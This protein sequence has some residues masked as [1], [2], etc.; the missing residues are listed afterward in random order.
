MVESS[1]ASTLFQRVLM[2]AAILAASLPAAEICNLTFTGCPQTFNGD[3]IMVP[4][5]VVK[6]SS[7]VH[8]CNASQT[9]TVGGGG[10]TCS[11]VF[12]IDNT[13]SM[14]GANGND[15]TGARFTVTKALLD[16]LFA[17]AP[18]TEVGLVV[19]REHLFF[20]TTTTEYYT[21]YFKTLNTVL[22][23][24]PD[25][26]YLP[27]MTLNQTYD[28]KLGIDIIKD[29]L[30]QDPAG[31]D[32]V[33]Q[34][35]WAEP[36]G[37]E[38]NINGAFIGV[39]QAF[40]SAKNPKDDQYVIFMSD[41]DPEGAAQAGLDPHWFDTPAGTA[42]MPTTFTVFFLKGGGAAPADIVTMTQNIQTNA[43]STS[44]PKSNYWSL[45]NVSYTNL[46][47]LL[48]NNV[49]TNL[50]LSGNPTKMVLNNI[51]ST[52]YV[53]SSFFFTD[54]F[55]IANVPT[56]FTM[57]ITYRYVNPTTNILQDTVVA[58]HFYVEQSAQA[59]LP[60]G[61]GEI[62]QQYN[63]PAL[64]IPVTATLLDTN[65][66]GHIDRIDITWTDTSTINQVMPTV[67][68]FIQ[69][70]QITTLDGQ[71][72]TL[73]AVSIQ[74]DL[75]NKTIHIILSE[76]TGNVYETAWQPNPSIILTNWPMSTSGSPFVVTAVV[77][78]TRPVIRSVCFAPMPGADTLHVV[79]S[80]PIAGLNPAIDPNN[81]FLLFTSSGQYPFAANNPPA[82][83][84]ADMLVYVFPSNTLSGL[85]SIVDGAR[86]AFHLSTCGNVSIVV[87]SI[88]TVNPFMPGKSI[89]PPNQRNGG[90]AT[91][92]RIE[93]LLI[94]AIVGDKVTG[95]VS[96]FDAVGNVVV[97]RIP[98]FLDITA[99]SGPKLSWGWD[100]KTRTG[101]WA[102][103]GTYLARITISDPA[104]NT[105]Q[106][107]RLNIGIKH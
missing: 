96:I 22:D 16:T 61:V 2:F 104:Q 15:P 49:V 90:P 33:Y 31:D 71:K 69:T 79:Y 80:S 23:N 76:N 67:A 29:I 1:N 11:I 84:H 58:V 55:P 36:T 75:A 20:D 54:S 65:H 17:H 14:K 59:T 5:N 97:N 42:N 4:Q 47:T 10:G 70:L 27:F 25:Q 13:G 39:K 102:A 95:T 50:L 92:T 89:I 6:I 85:D 100:G 38:T 94:P 77:N 45:A 106:N 103:P 8:A 37:G 99:V 91:G 35:N 51:T 98:M 87:K 21:K 81:A 3:T 68:Q 64:P 107:I 66:N 18:Q 73:T 101:S 19:F 41:G 7:L 34:P 12:V 62:C 32:L 74:P 46:M 93:V 78:G 48:M 56:P 57:N 44:N 82:S 30:T 9:I 52:V 86:P 28:G 83:V 53:D 26:A 105:T 72:V 43:Y 88:A 60:P 63:G 40:Q 24:Q